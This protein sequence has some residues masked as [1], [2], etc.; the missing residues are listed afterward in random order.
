MAQFP[1]AMLPLFWCLATGHLQRGTGPYRAR[2]INLHIFCLFEQILHKLFLPEFL[3]KIMSCC[4]D[5]AV[6]SFNF[7]AGFAARVLQWIASMFLLSLILSTPCCWCSCCCL[8][9]FF[10]N[11]PYYWKHSYNVAGS[12]CCYWCSCCCASTWCCWHPCLWWFP[13]GFGRL[14]CHYVPAFTG[15]P[16][17]AGF[18]ALASNPAVLLEFLL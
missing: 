15:F 17:L 12:P 4:G 10:Y 1:C 13:P 3:P 14:F 7:V 8:N 6:D 2:V 18:H 16:T 11:H 5:P 9:S